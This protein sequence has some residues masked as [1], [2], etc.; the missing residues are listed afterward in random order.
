MKA[1][2]KEMREFGS[3]IHEENIDLIMSAETPTGGRYKELKQ[4][5]AVTRKEGAEIIRYEIQ[6]ASA[7]G[8]SAGK[9]SVSGWTTATVK[10][11]CSK[12]CRQNARIF[13][14]T[15]FGR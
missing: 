4:T 2:R 1:L 6:T 8:K 7:Y 12:S 13:S 15:T 11:L 5:Y 9:I 3:A 14:N 10:I